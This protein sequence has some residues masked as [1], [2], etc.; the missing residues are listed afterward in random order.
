MFTYHCVEGEHR[1]GDV[2]DHKFDAEEESQSGM[3]E[4][5]YMHRL[6]YESYILLT[7]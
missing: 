6:T 3:Y 7:I 1:K 4:A 5:M 2:D